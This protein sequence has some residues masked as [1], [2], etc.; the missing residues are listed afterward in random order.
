M[1][2]VVF[3]TAS[4][5]SVVSKWLPFSFVFS[6]GTEKSMGGGDISHVVF[7]QKFSDEKERVRRC[8]VVMQQPI[9]V[10]KVQ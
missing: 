1:R 4:I 5:T 8:V 10:I 3:T 6:R 7:G 2:K 9:F